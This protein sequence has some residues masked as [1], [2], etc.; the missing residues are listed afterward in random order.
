M[1]IHDS[2]KS[3]GINLKDKVFKF[4]NVD[5]DYSV[6]E[7]APPP[8]GTKCHM[9]IDAQKQ[10]VFILGNIGISS[11]RIDGFPEKFDPAKIRK[12]IDALIE[13]ADDNPTSPWYRSKNLIYNKFYGIHSDGKIK[14]LDAANISSDRARGFGYWR[15]IKKLNTVIFPDDPMSALFYFANAKL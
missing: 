8:L 6:Y 12:M 9:L 1:L 3:V 10:E 5:S 2:L 14:E 7:A 11:L 15:K 4:F 13:S